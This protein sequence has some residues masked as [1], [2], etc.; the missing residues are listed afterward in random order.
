MQEA[1]GQK[2]M[3][4]GSMSVKWR[5][6]T[7]LPSEVRARGTLKKQNSEQAQYDIACSNQDGETLLTAVAIIQK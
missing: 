5:G 7:L 4:S 6:P 2:W 3:T 1:F